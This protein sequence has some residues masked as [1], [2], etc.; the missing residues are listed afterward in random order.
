MYESIPVDLFCGLPLSS[1]VLCLPEVSIALL[2]RYQGQCWESQA[3]TGILK[4]KKTAMS[5]T[6]KGCREHPRDHEFEFKF[7]NCLEVSFG[8]G[9]A[10][11]LLSWIKLVLGCLPDWYIKNYIITYCGKY[12]EGNECETTIKH[13]FWD[14]VH[15]RLLEKWN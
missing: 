6:R 14:M 7:F 9:R 10:I 3:W 5:T 8:L 1:V 2:F 12:Q 4:K 13:N 11:E 15:M